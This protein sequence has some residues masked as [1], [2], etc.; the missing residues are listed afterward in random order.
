LHYIFCVRFREPNAEA[1]RLVFDMKLENTVTIP[2]KRMY[3]NSQ[4]QALSSR[5]FATTS[6]TLCGF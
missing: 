3:L 5:V 2:L 1:V 6:V 4:L